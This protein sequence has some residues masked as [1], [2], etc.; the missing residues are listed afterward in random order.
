M[1]GV[2][3]YSVAGKSI[4]GD[5]AQPLQKVVPSTVAGFASGL[6]HHVK[7]WV[8]PMDSLVDAFLSLLGVNA[9]GVVKNVLH[10]STAANASVPALLL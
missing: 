1:F 4:P 5:D 6:V 8:P 10:S 9:S 7:A 2:L 3:L